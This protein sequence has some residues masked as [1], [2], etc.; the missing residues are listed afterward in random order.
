[1]VYGHTH[2]T[3]WQAKGKNLYIPFLEVKT[4][5]EVKA[6]QAKT[7][8]AQIQTSHMLFGDE[9]EQ[10]P[11]THKGA[12]KKLLESIN[13]YRDDEHVRVNDEM[14]SKFDFRITP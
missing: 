6:H 9:V 10:T 13:A 14:R 1:M 12:F 7:V 5:G 2:A 11:S 8:G 4:I 3:S